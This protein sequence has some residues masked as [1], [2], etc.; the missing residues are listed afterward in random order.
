MYLYLFL[1]FSFFIFASVHHYYDQVH[2]Q[3]T[4]SY[5]MSDVSSHCAIGWIMHTFKQAAMKYTIVSSCT[6]LSY[7]SFDTNFSSLGFFGC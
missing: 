4:E 5:K 3:I 2:G 7:Q 6:L 1:S